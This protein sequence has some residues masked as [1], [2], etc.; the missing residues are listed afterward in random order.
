MSGDK[1]GKES[2]VT[3]FFGKAMGYGMRDLRTNTLSNRQ[4]P[5]GFARE[6]LR[7]VDRKGRRMANGRSARAASAAWLLEGRE[8][9]GEM[10]T[11]TVIVN[12]RTEAESA[13]VRNPR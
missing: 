9:A 8:I 3:V 1:E 10:L 11:R 7:E 6:S 12:A 13:E 4:D 5:T 2:I